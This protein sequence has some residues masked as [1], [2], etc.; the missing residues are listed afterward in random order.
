ML[1]RAR[2]RVDRYFP[3]SVR[4]ATGDAESAIDESFQTVAAP[5]TLTNVDDLVRAGNHPRHSFDPQFVTSRVEV[6][7]SPIRSA[8]IGWIE[9][10]RIKRSHSAGLTWAG[11]TLALLC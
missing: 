4:R 8:R 5:L 9:R 2:I 10:M 6:D 1:E 3:V 7:L 11:G